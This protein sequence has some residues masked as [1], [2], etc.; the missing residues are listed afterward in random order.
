MPASEKLVSPMTLL[1]QA[2]GEH[3]RRFTLRKRRVRIGADDSADIIVRCDGAP[4]LLCVLYTNE[5]ESQWLVKVPSGVARAAPQPLELNEPRRIG[6]VSI[7]L[8]PDVRQPTRSCPTCR[9]PMASDAV[10]CVSCGYDL[11]TRRLIGP[12]ALPV[13]LTPPA[14]N[15]GPFPAVPFQ[16]DQRRDHRSAGESIGSIDALFPVVVLVVSIVLLVTHSVL[17][18][19]EN[20]LRHALGLVL[21]WTFESS[22]LV[23]ALMLASHWGSFEFGAA[24]RGVLKCAAVVICIMAATVWMAQA[25]S[26]ATGG[27]QIG[28]PQ[29]QAIGF[30]L[31][32]IIDLALLMGL[33]KRFFELEFFELIAVAAAQCVV[34]ITLGWLY[35]VI[36]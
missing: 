34:V 2:D 29:G 5:E 21:Q 24:H 17:N 10:L 1:I 32:C 27:G 15:A 20:V 6:P 19:P 23:A 25:L 16:A 9:N 13:G 18:P 33:I 28:A 35:A 26:G 8:M 36:V 30:V 3:A 12:P 11:R 31:M 22:V 7:C 4:P 14:V